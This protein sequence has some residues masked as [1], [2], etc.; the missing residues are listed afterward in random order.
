[1]EGHLPTAKFDYFGPGLF[2]PVEEDSL[3]QDTVPLWVLPT[4]LGMKSRYPLI[5][6]EYDPD[7]P[8]ILNFSEKGYFLSRD[9]G[10]IV[11]REIL[12]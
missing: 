5:N 12:Y 11:D 10:K 4:T 1:L 3:F 8:E 9:S 2:V 6:L 7:E